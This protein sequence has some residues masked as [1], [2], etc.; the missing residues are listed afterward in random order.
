MP[1]NITESNINIPKWFT[2]TNFMGIMVTIVTRNA[3]IILRSN[4]VPTFLFLLN[5]HQSRPGPSRPSTCCAAPG[6]FDNF[7]NECWLERFFYVIFSTNQQWKLKENWRKTHTWRS[8]LCRKL[9]PQDCT[10]IIG[11]HWQKNCLDDKN[12]WL[13]IGIWMLCLYNTQRFPCIIARELKSRTLILRR[14]GEVSSR[15]ERR[16]HDVGTHHHQMLGAVYSW[17]RQ[18]AKYSQSWRRHRILIDS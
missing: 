5:C 14:I 3:F 11:P 12:Y 16:H 8:C 6:Y 7:T 1:P 4:N 9:K 2:E 17:K 15:F 13:I 10:F 18:S